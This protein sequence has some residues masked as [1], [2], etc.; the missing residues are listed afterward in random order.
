MYI[1][2]HAISSSRFLSGTTHVLTSHQPLFLIDVGKKNSGIE[3]SYIGYI[4][5][6]KWVHAYSTRRIIRVVY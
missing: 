5:L 6:E 3:G 2:Y 4:W 1:V